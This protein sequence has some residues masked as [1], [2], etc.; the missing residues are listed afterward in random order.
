MILSGFI[1]EFHFIFSRNLIL[2][3]PNSFFSLFFETLPKIGSFR[4]PTHRRD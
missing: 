1:F 2:Y 3:G 4:L